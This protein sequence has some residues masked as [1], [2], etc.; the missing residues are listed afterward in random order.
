MHLRFTDLSMP[1]FD[2][3]PILL[4]L[5]I[6]KYVQRKVPLAD[7]YTDRHKQK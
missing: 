1:G 5:I 3:I 2:S 6:F 7:L 4:T